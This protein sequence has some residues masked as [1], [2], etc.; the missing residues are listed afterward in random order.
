MQVDIVDF[1][2]T[3]VAALEHC[4]PMEKLNDTIDRFI[5]WRR[6]SGLSPQGSNR[7]FGIAYDNPETTEPAL[8]RFD[9][10]GEVAADVPVNVQGV[11]AKTIP[12]GRCARV[13]HYGAHQR[14]GESISPLYRDWLPQS[15]EKLRD[16]PLYFHYVNLFPET[17]ETE[18]VTDI[19]LPLK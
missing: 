11:I 8:Y 2:T 6:E 14:L 7:T 15:G 19:Y 16:F 1:K 5:N 4:G 13:R 9:I 17:R 10:C 18:L 12:G 3:R